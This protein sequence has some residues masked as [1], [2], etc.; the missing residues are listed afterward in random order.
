ML[1]TRSWTNERQLLALA[2]DRLFNGDLW[3]DL[4]R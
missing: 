4:I 2:L 3:A 1:S